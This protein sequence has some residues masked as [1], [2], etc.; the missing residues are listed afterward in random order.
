MEEL[1]N[2]LKVIQDEIAVTDADK[3][4]AGS[5]EE[6]LYFKG[7]YEGLRIAEWSVVN[8]IRDLEKANNGR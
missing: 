1:K 8:R 6:K 5:S 4:N 3:R 2:M 7:V